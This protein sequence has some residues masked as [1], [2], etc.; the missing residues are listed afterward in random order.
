MENELTDKRNLIEKSIDILKKKKK[1][2]FFTIFALLIFFSIIF[3]FNYNQN[4]KNEKVSE[5]YIK[6]GIYLSSNEIEKS[7]LLYKKIVLSKNKFYSILALNS[8]IENNLEKN[9]DEILKLFKIIE[10]INVEKEQLNL[11]KLKKAL[12]LKKIS[13][14]KEGNKLLKEIIEDSSIWKDAAMEISKNK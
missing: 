14:D 5:Q 3:F 13:R 10:S 9:N 1:I 6:A 11:V 4:I 8:I 2:S 7:K 12:Y